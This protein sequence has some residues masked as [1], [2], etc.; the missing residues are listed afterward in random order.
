[1]IALFDV[2]GL[3]STSAFDVFIWCGALLLTGWFLY[4]L[5][6][7]L[8]AGVDGAID[9]QVSKR[10]PPPMTDEEKEN[11]VFMAIERERAAMEDDTGQSKARKISI[12]L[13]LILLCAISAAIADAD[14]ANNKIPLVV[15]GVV[16]ILAW[17]GLR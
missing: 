15:A 12:V 3:D 10:L 8:P 6:F 9:R 13:G 17:L 2:I 1:M 7:K 4:W 5:L 14:W 11:A 16:I